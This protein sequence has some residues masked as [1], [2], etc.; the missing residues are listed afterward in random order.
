ML[1]APHSPIHFPR[2][3]KGCVPP[4]LSSRPLRC[5][6]D[7][8]PLAEQPSSLCGNSRASFPAWPT[9]GRAWSP[10]PAPSQPVA[11][12]GAVSLS[13]PALK[14]SL[15]PEGRILSLPRGICEG[16]E[17]QAAAG[18]QGRIQLQNS[19]KADLE[20]RYLACVTT[21]VDNAQD[22]FYSMGCSLFFTIYIYICSV[23]CLDRSC[24]GKEMFKK[25]EE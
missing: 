5:F 6:R 12:E 24:F 13:L 20:V 2:V 8:S 19:L 3:L 9:K 25:G 17:L 23:L 15:S 4:T 18:A 11:L 1:K 16:G 7:R 22:V 14:A 10:P 21:A